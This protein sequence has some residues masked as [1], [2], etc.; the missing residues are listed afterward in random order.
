MEMAE[1]L[2]KRTTDCLVA[3]FDLDICEELP[4]KNVL[5]KTRIN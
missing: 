2:I 1:H 4:Q 5:T 3:F